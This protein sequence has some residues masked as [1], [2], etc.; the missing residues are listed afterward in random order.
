MK[1][2]NRQTD[3]EF[4][5]ESV[6]NSVVYQYL[7]SF[8]T[9]LS[10]LIFYIYIVRILNATIVGSIALLLAISGLFSLIFSFGLGSSSRHFFSYHIGK[11][12]GKVP[13]KLITTILFLSFILSVTVFITTYML[14]QPLSFV[15]FHNGSYEY[16]IRLMGVSISFGVVDTILI[17][18]LLGLQKFKYQAFSSSF[19]SISSYS[20]PIVFYSLHH[21]LGFFVIGWILSNF[22]VF[23]IALTGIIRKTSYS[24]EI[25][26]SSNSILLKY[27][28]PIYLS[29]V[30]GM[31]ATYIDRFVVAYFMPLTDIAIYNFA[32][33]F[34]SSIGFLTIPV[35]HIILP[36]ISERYSIGDYTNIKSISRFSISLISFIYLPCAMGLAAISNILITLVGGTFYTGAATPLT[37]M[38]MLGS[39]SVPTYVFLQT[40]SGTRNTNALFIA[41]VSALLS[42]FILSIVLIPR[43]GLIGAAFSFSSASLITLFI[44]SLYCI[45]LGVFSL[46]LVSQAKIFASAITMY[47]TITLT[48]HYLKFAVLDF[49]IFIVEGIIVY[50]FAIKITKPIDKHNIEGFSKSFSGLFVSIARV[51]Q[52]LF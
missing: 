18:I 4:G 3:K 46:N 28:L 12:K 43:Y 48:S 21:T 24:A 25:E 26:T 45:K 10:G 8:I 42:N 7:S 19:Q 50:V 23:L 34:Y 15:F 36:K 30:V 39:I 17:G 41:S 2:E 9:V 52:W 14:A 1:V 5:T 13:L 32:L 31:G 44:Y 40:L 35:N 6:G 37:I 16:A 27:T 11:D 51:A 47:L 29:A 33:L 38:L 20:F 49:P 22:I